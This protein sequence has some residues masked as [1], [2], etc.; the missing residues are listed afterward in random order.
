M[1]DRYWNAI[2]ECD[3]RFDG[4]FYYAVRTTGVFCHPSCKSKLPNR[5]N[6]NIYY[7]SQQPVEEGFRPC[8]RCRPDRRSGWSPGRE[9]VDKAID[10][11]TS[12][13]DKSWRLEDLSERLFV[14]RYYLHRVFRDHIHMTPNE[15]LQKIRMDAA[16]KMIK[17]TDWTITEIA[18]KVGFK[19]SAHFSTVFQK[20]VGAA[21]RDFRSKEISS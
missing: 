17:E 14:D 16:R 4:L 15:F 20:A 9:L 13:Y 19:N 7:D 18:L 21:P 5:I 3:K 6:V 11:M 8:K 1:E 2:V 10:I 12:E